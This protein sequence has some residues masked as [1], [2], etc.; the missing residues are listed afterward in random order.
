MKPLVIIG[1]GGHG[2]EAVDIIEAMNAERPTFEVIGF[3]DDGREPGSLASPYDI[4]V[5][6]GLDHLRTMNVSYVLA[7]GRPDIRRRLSERLT[8]R[9]PVNI[10]HPLSSI[11]SHVE[12]GPGLIMAAGSRIT[13]SVR[14]GQHVHLNVNATVSHDCRVGDFVTVTP[15]VSISGGVTIGDDVWMGIGSSV[16][17]QIAI[18][19]RVVVGAG[20]AVIRDVR[21]DTTVVGVPAHPVEPRGDRGGTQ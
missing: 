11:G 10:V 6:G 20:A 13:H 7:I 15:G 19:D 8:D 18:G 21:A 3:I 16:I 5:L 17:Q 14:L 12:H 9:E 2:R 1:A 4:P